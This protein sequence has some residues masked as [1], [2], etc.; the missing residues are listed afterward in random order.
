MIDKYIS[1]LQKLKDK[2]INMES[3]PGM[4]KDKFPELT[5]SEAKQIMC[6][7]KSQEQVK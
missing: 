3:A 6:K 7:F 2:K 5:F 4:L 1:F